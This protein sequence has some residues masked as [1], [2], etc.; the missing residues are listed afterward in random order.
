MP[1]G[2][3]FFLVLDPDQEVREELCWSISSVVEAIVVF[4]VWLFSQHNK[5]HAI[6][7]PLQFQLPIKNSDVRTIRGIIIMK[8]RPYQL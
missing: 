5:T 1:F 6:R 8:L 7:C 3:D 4:F 2:I